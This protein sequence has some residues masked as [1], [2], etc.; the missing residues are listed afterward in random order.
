VY[1]RLRGEVP[2]AALEAYRR[3]GASVL[4]LMEHAEHRRLQCR[5]EGH[6]PWTMPAA[7]SAEILCA[8]N[9]FVLHT[10]GAAL[11]DADE[12]HHP[13]TRGYLPPAV[14][15]EAMACF[16]GAEAWACRVRQA[17]ANPGFRVDAPLP[18]ELPRPQVEPG[19]SAAHFQG[20]LRALH[21][22]H[23][24]A[25][26]ALGFVPERPAGVQAH[27]DAGRIRERYAAAEAQAHFAEGLWSTHAPAGVRARAEVQVRAALG[28]F[29]RVGQLIADPHLVSGPAAA[30][31]AA[32]PE[33]AAGPGPI[34]SYA[35]IAA[36]ANPLLHMD[37]RVR[38]LNRVLRAPVDLD[39][40]A[41]LYVR[42]DARELR[43]RIL[44][45]LEGR[46][47]VE[48]VEMLA[49]VARGDDPALRDVARHS[50]TLSEHPHAVTVREGIRRA[51]RQAEWEQP[52]LE[53]ADWRRGLE[54]R[55]RTLEAALRTNP[56]ASE[57]LRLFQAVNE[58]PLR[59]ILLFEL[60]RRTDPEARG[61]LW[62]IA[63][64]TPE[65]AVRQFAAE[66][67]GAADRPRE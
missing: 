19:T 20:L 34:T 22:V 26:A 31:R 66:L 49:R 38:A 54:E 59:G 63:R 65:W 57:L 5:I 42:L 27:T 60:Q 14:A 40:L 52:F 4:E 21:V 32:P 47:E 44:A 41:E 37:H 67:H 16:H 1:S 8:W 61:V 28:E 45:A 6:D 56:P 23:G 51:G 15:A 12:Q 58:L 33:A 25:A 46:P 62:Y 55:K 3:A 36:A 17:R 7:V 64:Y 39:A 24:H 53:V 2:G 29:L 18:A 35:L 50:L 43:V 30:P 48:A 10:L 11:L 13:G 9:A